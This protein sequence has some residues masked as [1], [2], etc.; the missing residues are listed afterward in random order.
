MN[1]VQVNSSANLAVLLLLAC[2]V[3]RTGRSTTLAPTQLKGIRGVNV[4]V[5]VTGMPTEALKK[6]I[7]A[8][9]ENELSGAGLLLTSSDAQ[10]FY[11][12]VEAVP[13]SAREEGPVA[14]LISARLRESV[15]LK[16]DPTIPLAND[17]LTWWK[18]CLKVSTRTDLSKTIEETLEYYVGEFAEHWRIENPAWAKAALATA[19]LAK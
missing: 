19:P 1:R 4:V 18:Q 14:L 5:N 7:Q 10:W 17:G 12:E 2:F 13:I 15:V 3:A 6:S 11:F 16:R 8:R 9:V